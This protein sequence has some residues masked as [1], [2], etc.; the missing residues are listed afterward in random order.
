M[1]QNKKILIIGGTGIVGKATILEALNFG[2]EVVTVSLER[3]ESIPLEVKQF[4]F[5]RN[6]VDSY[7]KNILEL[8]KKYG[9]WDIVFDVCNINESDAVQTYNCFKEYTSH[10]FILSTTL[11]YDRSKQFTLP[12]KSNH[13]LVDYGIMGGY[14]DSKLGI[15]NFWAKVKDV[16]WT[17]LRPYHI[18]GKGSSLGCVPDHNRDVTLIDKIKNDSPLFLC[19]NGNIE[20][21]CVNP[22][23]IARVVLNSF[24]KEKTFFK[25]Y[26]VVNP[27]IV[28]AKEY[29]N[30]IGKYFKKNINIINKPIE[31]VW[32]ENKGWQ[33]T[34]LPHIYDASDLNN[35]IGFVPNINLEKSINDAIEN[36]L[37]NKNVSSGGVH[38]R[39]TMP[40]RPKIIKWL[41]GK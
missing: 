40:P 29:Y 14:V 20:I 26:N 19:N 24:G 5:D 21:N 7:S 32:K 27:D 33:L 11:V 4:L 10:F 17:I 3:D 12:I 28:L 16:N 30:L 37:N 25:A 31:V 41:L 39:M 35:D 6:D 18:I 1:K 22:T 2:F 38:S 23:D 15:E 36:I 8:N 13:P 34:T 9:K